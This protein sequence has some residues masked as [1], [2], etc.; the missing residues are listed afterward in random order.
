MELGHEPNIKVVIRRRKS[1]DMEP[2][3][4]AP[5]GTASQPTY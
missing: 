5:V 1:K 2:A 3:L 4:E